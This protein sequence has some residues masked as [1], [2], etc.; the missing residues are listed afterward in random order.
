MTSFNFQEVSTE[1]QLLVLP[2]ILVET[3]ACARKGTKT[4]IV[5]LGFWHWA[6]SLDIIRPL[7]LKTK[8]A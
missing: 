3:E 8:E 7:A 1:G 5:Y 6:I 4:T 2:T